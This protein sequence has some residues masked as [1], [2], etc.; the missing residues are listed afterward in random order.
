MSE[1]IWTDAEDE[2]QDC[3]DSEI[4]TLIENVARGHEI[5]WDIEDISNIREVLEGIIV[6][7]L[8]LMTS[9]DFYPYVELESEPDE[10]I[11]LEP[12]N[13]EPEP[14]PE[15]NEMVITDKQLVTAMETVIDDMDADDLAK[16]AGDALG[17]LCWYTEDGLYSFVPDISYCGD[18]DF[19]KELKGN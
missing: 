12:S 13:P 1:H 2:R 16:L 6:D 7:K 8:N 15:Q 5:E 17:G 19:T 11:I 9:Y 3:V 4:Q 14:E 10:N 18:L